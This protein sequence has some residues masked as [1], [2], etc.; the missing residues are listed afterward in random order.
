MKNK[1]LML[2]AVLALSAL[3]FSHTHARGAAEQEILGVK[4]ALVEAYAKRD[5]AAFERLVAD[6]WR[7]V[8]AG[9]ELDKRG[10][11]FKLSD[12]RG[13]IHS[14][15]TEEDRLNVFADTAILTGLVTSK[16][17]ND[18]T[19]GEVFVIRH[20]YTDVF[21]KQGGR[22]RLAHTHETLVAPVKVLGQGQEN[23][24]GADASA[25]R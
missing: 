13:K 24:P 15:N 5:A 10:M 1:S 19:P 23:G 21:V 20:R 25:G 4:K 17:S 8:D 16:S 11:L 3:T 12:K 9:G 6:D 18:E 7:L 2:L 14:I 22:W